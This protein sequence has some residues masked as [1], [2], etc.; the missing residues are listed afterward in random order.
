MAAPDEAVQ[1]PAPLDEEG[2]V[3]HVL[4]ER[5]LEHVGQLGEAAALVDQLE[6][7]E[8]PEEV[9]GPLPDLGQAVDQAPGELAPDHRGELERRLGAS[10]QPVDAGRDHVLDR[11]G[12]V[13]LR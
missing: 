13:D 2:G 1:L 4:G 11:S 12:T 7:A 3:G 10:A 6:R 5:V 9:V 8:L